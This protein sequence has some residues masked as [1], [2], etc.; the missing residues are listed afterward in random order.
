M[1]ETGVTLAEGAG[2]MNLNPAGLGLPA[3]EPL[4]VDALLFTEPLLPAFRIPGLKHT[5]FAARVRFP[6]TGRAEDLGGFGFAVNHIEFGSIQI[7]DEHGVERGRV[8]SYE[9]VYSLA[10]GMPLV[11]TENAGH[12]VGIGID[13]VH[14]ALAPEYG[15]GDEGIGRTAAVDVGYLIRH[16]S[17]LRLGLTLAN[18]GPNIYYVSRDESYP[19]PFCVSPAAGYQHS[20]RSRGLE[21]FGVAFEYRVSREI[22]KNYF[23]ERPDPFWKAIRTDFLDESWDDRIEEALNHVG[24]ELTIMKTVSVRSGFM[25]DWV[26]YRSEK[27]FGVGIHFLNHFALGWSYIGAPGEASVARHGQWS[28]CLNLT[29]IGVWKPSD[30]TWWLE[31]SAPLG[32]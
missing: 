3:R 18:M 13:Y 5:A 26:G 23:D 1:G 8:R 9:T 31:D 4:S 28:A 20:F 10:W 25:F 17:G 2:A 12:Y 7:V 22:A 15:E 27:H 29:N 32:P 14:S 11:R 6:W 21:L 19:I 16:S 24:A 30:L